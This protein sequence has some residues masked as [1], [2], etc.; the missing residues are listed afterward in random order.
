MRPICVLVIAALLAAAPASAGWFEKKPKLNPAERVGQ[1][2][3]A[4]KMDPDAGKRADAANELRG[5]DGAMYPEVIPALIEALQKDASASVRR[6]A[7]QSLGRIKPHTLEAAQALDQAVENDSSTTVRL[8]ARMSRTGYRVTEPKPSMPGP[9]PSP[10][11]SPSEGSIIKLPGMG[12]E[13][14]QPV[15]VLPPSKLLTPVSRPL[16]KPEGEAKPLPMPQ[17]KPA[18]QPEPILVEP[19]PLSPS[20]SSARPI[21]PAA[22][23]QAEK[24]VTPGPIFAAPKK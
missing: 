24:P 8:Q 23:E 4:L 6:E 1:L 20:F 16:P 11:P 19:R 14:P 9:L 10:S 17:N 21:Q 2:L 5:Y 13:K 7:A 18:G 15:Q 12:R 3:V 22:M